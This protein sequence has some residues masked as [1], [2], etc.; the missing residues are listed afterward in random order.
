MATIV[1]VLE[2]TQKGE[3]DDLEYQ[4]VPIEDLTGGPTPKVWDD[5]LQALYRACD[6]SDEDELERYRNLK[7][8]A[9]EGRSLAAKNCALIVALKR[10]RAPSDVLVALLHKKKKGTF[11]WDVVGVKASFLDDPD[12]R[13]AEPAARLKALKEAIGE[14]KRPEGFSLVHMIL[15]L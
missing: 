10:G 15:P 1:V 13:D 7:E 12:F 6:A 8:V 11:P 2:G 3:E 9:Y 14:L 5:D 4:L